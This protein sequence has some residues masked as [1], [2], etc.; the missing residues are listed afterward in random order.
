MFSIIVH[1]FK[2]SWN[3]KKIHRIFKKV[4]RFD[5]GSLDKKIAHLRKKE[6]GI[7]KRKMKK[8]KKREKNL[9]TWRNNK[10]G[11]RGL[12]TASGSLPSGNGADV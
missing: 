5:K 2:K 9:A 1:V 7:K 3:L 12:Q 10:R 4:H 8:G 6:K 11:K